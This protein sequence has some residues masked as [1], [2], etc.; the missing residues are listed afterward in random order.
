MWNPATVTAEGLAD[1][2]ARQL[3]GDL[4]YAR[5]GLP[6][7]P[8][9][10]RGGP[11]LPRRARRTPPCTCRGP[12]PPGGR[13]ADAEPRRRPGT[14][15]GRQT[16]RQPEAVSPK[17]SRMISAE[18]VASTLRAVSCSPGPAVARTAAL[19]NSRSGL[20]GSAEEPSQRAAVAPPLVTGPWADPE[21]VLQR[22]GVMI[23]CTV[24]RSSRTRSRSRTPTSSR[25]SARRSRPTA[26]PAP[27]PTCARPA[28]SWSRRS[29]R[30]P[31]WTGTRGRSRHG[32]CSARTQLGRCCCC[33]WTGWSS[34]ARSSG[35]CTP[36]SWRSPRRCRTTRAGGSGRRACSTTPASGSSSRRPSTVRSSRTGCRAAAS[37]SWPPTPSRSATRTRGGSRP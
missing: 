25:T 22:E 36:V 12:R 19:P 15:A 33:T 27:T 6:P 10:R 31:I 2:F 30:S 32:W 4:G 9:S 35:A 28:A 21:Q 24:R 13:P 34:C 18:G 11:A 16:A 23:R 7:R 14:P 1:A 5:L 26:T 17:P 3:Y 29:S 8:S 20:T 37:R